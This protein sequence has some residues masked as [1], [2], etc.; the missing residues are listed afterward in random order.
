MQL[1]EETG[2]G[3]LGFRRP[4]GLLGGSFD[5]PHVGHIHISEIAVK[6]LNL[7]QIYWIFAKQNPL[8]NKSPS[9]F[10]NRFGESK[11][12]LKT[13]KIKLSQIEIIK[14]FKYSFELLQFLKCKNRNV[15]F[16]WIMGEDNIIDFHLWKN[17]KWIADNTRIAIV[18]RGMN[19]SLVNSSIFAQKYKAFRLPNRRAKQ[20]QHLKPPIW[21]S[22]NSRKIDISSTGLRLNDK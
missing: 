2:L 13:Q 10:R 15:T 16:I 6:T 3:R 1:N 12:L 4:I 17:W 11:K 21:C 18:S 7:G 9:S 5:P 19:K 20:L 22:I 14:G 8:K